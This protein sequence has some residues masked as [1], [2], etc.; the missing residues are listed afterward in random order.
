M[1]EAKRKCEEDLRDM[2]RR[3]NLT[4]KV[5]PMTDRE[6]NQVFMDT[7]LMGQSWWR[8]LYNCEK[9]KTL[10]GRSKIGKLNETTP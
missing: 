8:S 4:R 3:S 1:K 6:T 10:G 9:L 5:N 2:Y 7:F